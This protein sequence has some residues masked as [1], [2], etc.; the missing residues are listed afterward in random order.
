MVYPSNTPP[1]P[2]SRSGM[3]LPPGGTP[4]PARPDLPTGRRDSRVWIVGA[5][6]VLVLM[7]VGIT[8]V[9]LVEADGSQLAMP[10]TLAG[11]DRVTGPEVDELAESMKRD[12]AGQLP[13][14]PVI[15]VYGSLV[16]PKFFVIA[17]AAPPPPGD[18]LSGLNSDLND[19]GTRGSVDLEAATT[20]TAGDVTFTCVPYT[21]TTSIG[22]SVS[23]EV[24]V[25]TATETFGYVMTFDP[26]I[27]GFEL[28]PQVY[29][30]ITN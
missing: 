2:P 15:G 12:A 4:Q 18:P 8:I 11:Y 14:E 1:P 5:V 20:T 26:S 25:W 13:R 6:G 23:A 17:V 28:L 24:C 30:A 29:E 27:R 3:P 22:G 16:E 10:D 21:M 7:I 9:A 19:L